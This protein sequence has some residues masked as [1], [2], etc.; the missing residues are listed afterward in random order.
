MLC[1]NFGWNWSSGS[2]GRWKFEKFTTTATMT[3]NGQ[4]LTRKS[5]LILWFT[6]AKK[7]QEIKIISI[8]SIYINH[9]EDEL[10]RLWRKFRPHKQKWCRYYQCITSTDCSWRAFWVLTANWWEKLPSDTV[11]WMSKLVEYVSLANT[12]RA[13]RA[14]TVSCKTRF[15]VLI[16][17]MTLPWKL[18]NL[19]FEYILP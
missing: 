8:L 3:D 7:I 5:N 19:Q 17:Q 14:I 13:W 6:W 11:I 15:V 12:D 4:I 1:V 10:G 9:T 2:W 18:W 16:Y